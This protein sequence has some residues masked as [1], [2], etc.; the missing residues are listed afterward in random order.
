VSEPKVNRLSRRALFRYSAVGIAAVGGGSLL[1]ACQTTNPDTGQAEGGGG[2]LQ[3]R[4]DSGQPVRL[5]IANEPPYTKLTADGE[6]TGAAPDVAKAV[7][8]RMGIENIEAKQSAYDT[9]IA[10]LTADRWDMVTAGLFMNQNRCAQV[11]YSSPV[12]VSTESL[13]VP[14]G[15]PKNL[16]TVDDIK[17]KD[18]Q[19][20][21][22]AGSYE[23]RTAKALGVDEGKLP[24]YPKAPD[25]LQGLQNGRVDGILLPTLTLRSLKEQQGGDFEVTEPLESIPTTGS[26]AAFRKSDT[27][28]HAKYN[29]ELRAFKETPE[30]DAILEQWGFS[31]EA[32][33]KAT[34]EELCATE[35]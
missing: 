22:L 29:E 9:M 23:L 13:A 19:I 35:A 28:F 11:L 7:L 12:I 30:F 16:H 27:E 14:A 24:T 34:T 26:G 18:V 10:G 25:A 4:V 17:N 5:V 1:G 21:V 8:K 20:A 3:Q 6:L 32:A 31:G 15:N 33:R 2:G